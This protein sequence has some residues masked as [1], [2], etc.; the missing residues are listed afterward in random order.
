MASSSAVLYQ[1]IA[2]LPKAS[3][4]DYTLLE[5]QG[6]FT[7]ATEATF[8]N[9]PAVGRL[10][11]SGRDDSDDKKPA[12]SSSLQRIELGSLTRTGGKCMLVID[13]LE[14][15]GDSTAANHAKKAVV[16][17]RRSPRDPQR[18]GRSA[19]EPER[20]ELEPSAVDAADWH[21]FDSL[22]DESSSSSSGS[23]TGDQHA[24]RTDAPSVGRKRS[25]SRS[26]SVRTA[27]SSSSWRIDGLVQTTLLFKTK[28]VRKVKLNSAES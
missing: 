10:E 11:K 14:L 25:R 18:L 1:K 21:V 20:A 2:P 28:P 16:V 17:L 9:A 3:A 4:V 22:D 19:D 5:M 24:D 26:R 13:T 27:A 7:L 15:Q 8:H 6:E 23:E 12:R